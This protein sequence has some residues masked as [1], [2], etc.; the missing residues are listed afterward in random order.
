MTQF[1]KKIHRAKR[2]LDAVLHEYP[3]LPEQF[4]LFRKD[5][6]ESAQFNWPNWCYM[7]IAAGIAV[8]SDGGSIDSIFVSS[9][10]A[11]VT[12]LGTWRMTQ[13]V[14]RYDKTLAEELI[15]T[16]IDDKLPT[17]HIF[18]LPH[19]CVYIECEQ[20]DL[21]FKSEKVKGFFAH[22]EYDISR[23]GTPELRF[24]F[25]CADD[26][27]NPSPKLLC[28]A[29]ILNTDSLNEALQ[30]VIKSGFS[31]ASEIIKKLGL[32]INYDEVAKASADET[33]EEI[34]PFLSLLLYLCADADITRRGVVDTL[35]NPEPKLT[36][37]GWKLF[38]AN[39]PLEF[40]VGY[41]IGASI[42]SA[43]QSAH[44]VND[45]AIGSKKT[46]HVR[47]AHWHTILSGK[48]KNEDGSKIS[49]EN[50]KREL[51]WIAPIFV[52]VDSDIT[53]T[54]RSVKKP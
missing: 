34:K 13:G 53:T 12:A 32:N 21:K 9:K 46:A 28:Q 2:I 35:K 17:E 20:L 30:N 40:D 18:L 4:D 6:G 50:R 41:R 42:R 31:T 26:L 25:D 45:N 15:K 8:V 23:G 16:D 51:R 54:V 7:P 37:E 19:W 14:F 52:N 10:P 33:S 36:R 27:R 22:L 3:K 38:A 11:I 47:S 1:Q 49:S 29:L 24:V 5:R 43:K 48:T 39:G 44:E